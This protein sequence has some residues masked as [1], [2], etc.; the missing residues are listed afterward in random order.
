MAR[1]LPGPGRSVRPGGL[2]GGDD[3]PPLRRRR[4]RREGDDLHLLA[5]LQPHA[6]GDELSHRRRAPGG[7]RQRHARRPRPRQH[8]ARAVGHQARLPRTRTRAHPRHRARAGLAAGD[9]RP[10]DARLRAHVEV[11]QSGH[12]AGGR[13]PR[14]DDRQD[15]SA[16][17]LRQARRPRL[18]GHR[19]SRPSAQSHLARSTSPR[20]I[21]R[22]TTTTCSRSTPRSNATRRA[23]SATAR[24]TP[25]S[26]SSPA[27]PRRGWPR[28]PSKRCARGRARRPLPPG[29]A[30]AVP[31]PSAP[32]AAR[33]RPA[34]SWSSKRAPASSRTSCGSRSRMPDVA[35]P[36]IES[37]RRLGGVLPSIEEIVDAVAKEF[38]AG[39]RG[40][41]V[42]S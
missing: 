34:G 15:R 6:R 20:P 22:R 17:L 12:P 7:R 37:V 30:L 32:A 41:E 9:A 18:G 40:M 11:P 3:R 38:P 25:T 8:R 14:P 35:P 31:D 13:L 21:S 27:T 4:R 36:R 19:R 42:A 5:R 2:R 10:H 28:A 23:P 33:A 24:R 29:D 26:S 1:L 39:S 16:A